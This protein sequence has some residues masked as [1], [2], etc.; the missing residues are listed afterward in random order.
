MFLWT[1]RKWPSLVTRSDR[2]LYGLLLAADAE[3]ALRTGK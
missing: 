2:S 1:V 3:S